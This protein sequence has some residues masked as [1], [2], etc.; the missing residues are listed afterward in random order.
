MLLVVRGDSNDADF[1]TKVTPITQ[2]EL[3][4]FQP[5]I[6]AI[7]KF[8]PYM[9]CHEKDDKTDPKNFKWK[10]D[11]NWPKGEYGCR[12]DL[13]SK[14][15]TELYGDLAQEF[16]EEY[17]PSGGD[18]NQYS[19]HTIVEIFTVKLDQKVFTASNHYKGW[20]IFA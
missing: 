19:L 17:V 4:R 11:H 8:K 18:C 3:D 6:E 1:V 13:G 2:K 10:H 15:I 5:L 7:K 16:D 14:N 20:S 9:G 12:T